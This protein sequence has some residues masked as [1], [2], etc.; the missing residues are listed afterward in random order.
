M[1]TTRSRSSPAR[2]S[3]IGEQFAR[4]L[5]E[6]GHDLVLVA[7]DAARLEALAKELETQHADATCEV[8]AGRPHR[9]R[10]SS[11]RSRTLRDRRAVDV[12]VNNAGLR[13]VRPVPRRSTST[14]RTREIQLNVVALVRLTH[15]AAAR[16]GRRAARGGILNVSSLAGLPAR[17]VERDLRRDEGVRHVVH[18]GGA[19]GAEGH[20]RRGHGAVPGLHAHRVPG[21]APTSPASDVPGLHVA[22]GRRGRARRARRARQEPGGRRCPARSTRSLGDVL[23]RHA[24]RASPAASRG[25]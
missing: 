3:G 18:R 14:P 5:A 20:R 17:P 11:R 13:H 21:S 10:R 8:L 23:E 2:P 22:G 16:D 12:L 6:R 24:A 1:S 15:A 9:R 4:Q 7:R 19:R 25:A